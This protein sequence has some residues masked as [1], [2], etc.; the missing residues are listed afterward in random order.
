[1]LALDATIVTGQTGAS[2]TAI[3]SPIDAVEV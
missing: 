2:R 3:P 1:M